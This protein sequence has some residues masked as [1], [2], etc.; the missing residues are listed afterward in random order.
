MHSCHCF[1]SD[2]QAAFSSFLRKQE[3]IPPL[4]S[5]LR[6]NDRFVSHAGGIF[7]AKQS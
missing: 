4:D 1:G 5:R 6:E 7:M 2:R 3:S